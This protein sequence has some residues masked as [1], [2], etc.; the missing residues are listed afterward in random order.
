[1]AEIVFDE[2]TGLELPSTSEI[3]EDLATKFQL[4]FQVNAEDPL[5]NVE[6]SSPMGQVL[7]SVVAE[8]EAKNSEIQYLANEVDPDLAGG[9]FLDALAALYGLDRKI[10]EPTVVTCQVTG[11]KDTVIPYGAIAQDEEGNQFRCSVAAGIQIGADGTGEGTFTAIEHGA[12]EV[13]AG[14]LT[15]IITVV[16]GWDSITNES[17]GATGRT[18]ETDAELRTRMTESYAINATSSVDAIW[19]NLAELEGVLDVAVLE[20][21]TGDTL[22]KYGVEIEPHSIAVCIVGGEDEAIAEVLFRRKDVGCGTT[23]TTTV[24]YTATDFYNAEYS[25]Q[26]IRPDSVTFAVRLTFDD[27]DMPDDEAE[28]I[29]TT[30]MNDFLGKSTNSRVSL[31]STVYA[32]RFYRS[33]QSVTDYPL[34]K[35]EVSLDG[36]SWADSVEIQA[37]Q[38]PTM[39]TEDVTIV[40]GG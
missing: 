25:Y 36:G 13:P 32:S 30:V 26:I 9:R 18:E 2:S 7:D 15:K 24:T 34:V 3:R 27:T 1:M 38:E 37:D 33:V 17:A 29:R 22:T 8:I 10:S 35:I 28:L 5:L 31:A 6:A 39:S 20:N 23:G 12:L 14:T 16:A 4:A 40:M 11:I 19:S 21:N